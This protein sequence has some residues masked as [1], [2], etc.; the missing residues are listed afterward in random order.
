MVHFPQARSRQRGWLSD[1]L[2]LEEIGPACNRIARSGVRIET[3]NRFGK[4]HLVRRIVPTLILLLILAAAVVAWVRIGSAQECERWAGASV[5]EA[6]DSYD[7]LTTPADSFRDWA[8]Q[9]F[10]R[11]SFELDGRVF[12]N[13]GGCDEELLQTRL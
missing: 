9:T 12:R 7:V 1:R 2:P 6:R 8:Q 11:T 10:A 5:R 13:P 3:P 4:G